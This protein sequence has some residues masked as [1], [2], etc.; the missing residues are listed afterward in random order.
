MSQ[1]HI[2]YQ[3]QYEGRAGF[4]FKQKENLKILRRTYKV[5]ILTTILTHCTV[6]TLHSWLLGG[7]VY[8]RPQ[9]PF[10]N[11]S[12]ATRDVP[13]LFLKK[14]KML[15]DFHSFLKLTP[16][17][18]ISVPSPFMMTRWMGPAISRFQSKCCVIQVW[19]STAASRR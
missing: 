19:C 11:D 12:F 18:T 5:C 1:S 14:D 13:T 17:L 10:K 7:S 8:K 15:L 3:C 2:R 4:I 16:G 6:Y 9:R